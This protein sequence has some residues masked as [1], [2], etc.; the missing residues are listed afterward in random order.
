MLTINRISVK[1]WEEAIRGMRNP[2]NSWAKS[3]SGFSDDSDY[4]DYHNILNEHL[5][6][7]DC[8]DI[9]DIG[10]FIGPNDRKLMKQLR[11]GGK[12]HAKYR[13]MITVW[14]DILAPLYWWKEFDTYKVGTVANSCSTMHKIAEK[15]FTFEEFSCEHLSDFAKN[16][17]LADTI[18]ELNVNRGQYLMTGEKEFWWNMIQLLPSSYNQKRTVMLNYEVL[19]NIYPARKNHKLDE[20]HTFCEVMAGL[21]DS[22]IF[23]GEDEE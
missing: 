1:G 12:D 14:C 7:E 22:W 11:D 5:P 13:R 15:E 23:T 2:L 19:A 21:P 18:H 17:I 8:C 10:H 3:D 4:M 16:Y 9:E 6:Y 20:W